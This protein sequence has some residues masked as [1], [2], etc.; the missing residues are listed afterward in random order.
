MPCKPIIELAGGK[1]PRQR[2]WAAIRA[3]AGT[4]DGTFTVD[5]LART[6]KLEI[7]PI[8]AYLRGLVAGGWVLI[9]MQGGRGVKNVYRLEKD[10]GIEAP[11]VRQDGSEVTQGSGNEAL[12][13][14]ITVLDS[15]TAQTIADIANVAPHTAKTYCL[16]LSRAGYLIVTSQGKGHGNGGV[17]T[18]YRTVKTRISGP[19]APM[20]TRLKVV[21][22]PNLHQVVWS[23][24]ADE[25]VKNAP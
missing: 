13:G 1:S 16:F 3:W 24:G 17:A 14:V 23:E 2:I 25:A 19:R 6:A 12:W 18:V 8:Q 22:D 5:G 15:F 9:V 20:I 21:Y 4:G 10:N 7:E 11:R